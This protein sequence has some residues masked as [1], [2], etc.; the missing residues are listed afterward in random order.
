MKDFQHH[1]GDVGHPNGQDGCSM[2]QV[3]IAH[4]EALLV[5]PAHMS[6]GSVVDC[7]AAVV[8]EVVQ[9]VAESLGH[10]ASHRF[11]LQ[12]LPEGSGELF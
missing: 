7:F 8:C 2:R 9:E 1:L 3:Q 10:L 4:F 12:P 11:V 6:N 5:R